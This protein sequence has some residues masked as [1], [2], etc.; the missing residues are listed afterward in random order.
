MRSNSHP[1]APASLA[2]I[3]AASSGGVFG[4]GST[5]RTRPTGRGARRPGVRRLRNFPGPRPAMSYVLIQQSFH[6]IRPECTWTRSAV[7]AS[8]LMTWTRATR[9]PPSQV[10]F[11]AYLGSSLRRLRLPATL[12]GAEA[13][14]SRTPRFCSASAATAARLRPCRPVA[15]K[16]CPPQPLDPGS[17]V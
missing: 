2:R 10:S 8:Q 16:Q 15:L 5:Y 4:H 12:S 3:F 14:G 11:V 17:T 6:A 9:Q 13:P 7:G 1:E